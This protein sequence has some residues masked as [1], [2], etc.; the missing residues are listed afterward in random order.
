M[1]TVYARVDSKGVVVDVNSDFFIKDFS[2]WIPLERGNGISFMHAQNNY[3]QKP[4]WDIKG[5]ANYK[6]I[7]GKIVERS[8]EEKRSDNT[9]YSPDYLVRLSRIESAIEKINSVL[10]KL[11]IK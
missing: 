8:E 5:S 6:F 10:N 2:G 1:Y 4:L 9:D 11:G 3:L 7:D